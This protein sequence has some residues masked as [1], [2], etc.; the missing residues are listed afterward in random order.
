MYYVDFNA[1]GKDYKLRL[2][3]RS[4]INLEKQLGENPISIFGN[5]DTIPTITTMVT[6]LH[7]SLQALHHGITLDNAYSIFD[8]YLADDHIMTD[9]LAVLVDIYKVSG[10]I[11]EQ[12]GTEKN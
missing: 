6:V 2:N 4:M 3:T 12:A 7:A 8:D 11:K 9:F 1:G 5:G 10:L